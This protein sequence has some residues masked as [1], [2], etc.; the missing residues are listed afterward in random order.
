MS[1]EKVQDE[2]RERL[3]ELRR[4]YKQMVENGEMTKEDA[5]F[6]FYMQKDDILHNMY[7]RSIEDKE[8]SI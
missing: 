6:C 4:E 1:N 7:L 3:K 2:Y 8:E 5:N